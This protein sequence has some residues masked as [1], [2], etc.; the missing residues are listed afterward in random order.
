MPVLDAEVFLI[1]ELSGLPVD[2]IPTNE[3]GVYEFSEIAVGHYSLYVD[4]P[5][6]TQKTTHRFSITETY[7]EQMNLDFVVDVVWDMD[8]NSVLNTSIPDAIHILNNISLYPNP[9]I[10]DYIIL[11]SELLDQKKMEIAIFSDIG[12]LMQQRDVYV[13]GDQVKLDLS[14]FAPGNYILRIKLDNEVQFK[15]FVLLKHK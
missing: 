11:Q 9:T 1:D 14:G 8:I 10:S 2:F 3:N 5:G 12:S 4:I 6:I 15:K 7:L 13:A